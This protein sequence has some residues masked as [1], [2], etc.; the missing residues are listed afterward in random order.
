MKKPYEHIIFEVS[1]RI[2]WIRFNRP[3]Q[4]NAMNFKMMNEIIDALETINSL[5]SDEAIIGIITGKGKA[6]MAGADIKEYAQQTVADFNVFQNKGRSIYAGIE[7]NSKPIIAAVNGYAF[8]GGF[9]IAL[10]CDMMIAS[11]YAKLALP[12]INLNLIPGV[13]GTQR[14]TKKLGLNLANELLMTGKVVTA[15]WLLERG[16][17]NRVYPKEDNFEARVKEFAEDLLDKQAD[18]LTLL[19][20]LTHSAAGG[21]DTSML[22][23]ENTQLSKFYVSEEGQEKIQGFYQKSLNK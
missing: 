16:L 13:G 12:E 1:E 2:A 17:I 18:R 15:D 23:L 5:P 7:G 8:G 14:L 21:V 4:L 11:A 19:K 6:F 10:A 3:D 9:E 22:N 20:I